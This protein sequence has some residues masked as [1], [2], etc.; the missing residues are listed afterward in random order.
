V[1]F[2]VVWQ[3]TRP[4]LLPTLRGALNIVA[5]GGGRVLMTSKP[6]QNHVQMHAA[7]QIVYP[8]EAK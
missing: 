3:L 1:R 6:V 7:W 5:T 2:F 8:W 4:V